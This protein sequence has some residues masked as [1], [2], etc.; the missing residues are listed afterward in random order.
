MIVYVLHYGNYLGASR[1][2]GVFSSRETAQSFF[3][4]RLKQ[5][6]DWADIIAEK[7]DQP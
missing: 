2:V 1:F 4:T 6:G 3:D 7:V 5:G